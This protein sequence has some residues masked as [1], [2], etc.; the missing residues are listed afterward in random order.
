MT[1]GV[2]A[3]YRRLGIG[4]VPKRPPVGPSV[5]FRGAD[6]RLGTNLLDHVLSRAKEQTRSNSS[7]PVKSLYLHVQTTNQEALDWYTKR[8][9]EVQ[10]TVKEYYRNIDDRS[11]YILVRKLED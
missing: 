11:A 7:Q 6:L 2:L 4:P 5:E 3:P 10:D 8:G 9:F 1:L